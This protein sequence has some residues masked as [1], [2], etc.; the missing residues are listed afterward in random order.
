MLSRQSGNLLF[1]YRQ[2]DNHAE[3]TCKDAKRRPA[4]DL[5][6][7]NLV[8]GARSELNGFAGKDSELFWSTGALQNIKFQAPN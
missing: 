2:E 1:S 6:L 5:V 7:E 4:N 8:P 3:Q